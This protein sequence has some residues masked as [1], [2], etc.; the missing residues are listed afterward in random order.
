M[1]VS[2]IIPV[3]NTE[4]YLKECLDSIINQNTKYKYEII[5][6]NDGS[7][8]NSLK[9]LKEYEKD[10]III[11]KENTG[12]GDS[13][14][15]AI[16]KSKGN[17]LLFVDS[18]DYVSENFVEI[19]TNEIIKNEASIVIC[20]MYR[21]EGDTIS[22]L[23]K[24]KKGIYEKGNINEVLLMEFHSCNKIFERQLLINNPY[25][26]GMFYEDVVAISGAIIDAE[27]T[28]KINEALYYYRRVTSST[29]NIINKT[30]SDLFKAI[31][32]IEKKFTDNGYKDEIEFLN[33]DGLL[34][35]VL[36]KL[37]KANRDMKEIKEIVSFVE[38]K[39]PKWYKNKYLKE[40]R[41]LKRLYLYC[42][43][44]RLYFIINL[45]YRKK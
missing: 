27:R 6:I 19:M 33:I 42:L 13:R 3:Y 34:V 18:D 39:Y 22:Y 8:D 40:E 1:D 17:Y 35:D 5:A 41:F 2:I 10:I 26:K 29:T 44:K 45:I 24:G 9:I 43:R 4:K 30:N 32:M 12:P 14:N 31:K 25:P 20:D 15:I 38:N 37:I 16:E 28:V 11:D 36:I 7:K 23:S 21:K